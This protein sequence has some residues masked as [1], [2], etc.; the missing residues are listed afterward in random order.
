MS[1]FAAN[2]RGRI[3]RAREAARSARASGEDDR[4]EA[5]DAD[6]GNLERLAAEH[7][8]DVGRVSGR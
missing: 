8:V 3:T 5:H 6:V 7:G 1:E 4:A 2:L